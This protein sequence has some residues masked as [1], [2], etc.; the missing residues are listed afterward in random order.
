LALPL[1]QLTWKEQAY[2]WD[3]QCEKRFPELKRRLTYASVLIMSNANESF[4]MHLRW[5]LVEC[6]CI[7]NKL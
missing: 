5:D 1:T 6:L 7:M 4:V 3:A 2:V